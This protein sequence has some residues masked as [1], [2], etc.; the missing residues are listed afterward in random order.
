MY[1]QIQFKSFKLY[2]F[3]IQVINSIFNLIPLYSSETFQKAKLSVLWHQ[4]EVVFSIPPLA[5]KIFK[6]SPPT[7]LFA[8]NLLVY[9]LIIQERHFPSKKNNSPPQKQSLGNYLRAEHP[10]SNSESKAPTTIR[11][12]NRL[13]PLSGKPQRT[14]DSR[15]RAIWRVLTNGLDELTAKCFSELLKVGRLKH[16]IRGNRTSDE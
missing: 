12:T 16:T 14:K 3:S 2:R 8:G 9:P 10:K 6:T 15:Y 1:R 7:H 5:P 13:F 11:S 4:T